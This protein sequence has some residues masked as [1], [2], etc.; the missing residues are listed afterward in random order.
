MNYE[1]IYFKCSC[2][3]TLTIGAEGIGMTFTCPECGQDLR[4]PEPA[5]K[6]QCECG[7][8]I[9]AHKSMIGETV[10]CL[11]CKTF[12]QVPGKQENVS[13][14]PELPEKKYAQIKS[15]LGT[16]IFSTILAGLVVIVVIS[17]IFSL[18][19]IE[20]PPL[21]ASLIGEGSEKAN[22][23][24]TTNQADE[25]Q[26]ASQTQAEAGVSVK[27]GSN[28]ANNQAAESQTVAAA[29]VPDKPIVS[30]TQTQAASPQIQSKE[31]PPDIKPVV[32]PE[33]LGR[34][35]KLRISSMGSTNGTQGEFKG[36]YAIT[37]DAINIALD[38][39][40][41]FSQ[42]GARL[43]SLQVYLAGAADDEKTWNIPG[44][45]ESV[46]CNLVIQPREKVHLK[47]LKFT[48][49]FTDQ[50]DLKRR[51]LSVK[52]W[53]INPNGD[54]EYNPAESRKDI[55]SRLSEPAKTSA[56]VV[57]AANETQM[58]AAAGSARVPPA[59]PP[60]MPVTNMSVAVMNMDNFIKVFEKTFPSNNNIALQGMAD[61]S[62]SEE[63]TDPNNVLRGKRQGLAWR[64]CDDVGREGGWF[65]AKWDNPVFGRFILFFK[66]PTVSYSPTGEIRYGGWR[67][68]AISVN[69]GEKF[70]I[71]NTIGQ[72][73]VMVD[74]QRQYDIQ[75]ISIELPEFSCDLPGLVGLEIHE[76][77]VVPKGE[78]T[79][80]NNLSLAQNW[81]DSPAA[82]RVQKDLSSIL[83]QFGEA[84]VDLNRNDGIIIFNNLTYLMDI[85]E[86]FSKLGER[87]PATT[88]LNT[89]YFA[90]RSFKCYTISKNFT[91]GQTTFDKIMFVADAKNQLIAVQ[92]VNENPKSRCLNSRGQNY[93]MYNI[94][95]NRQK[96]S[97]TARIDYNV[98]FVEGGSNTR[99]DK[100]N[101][102]CIESELTVRERYNYSAKEFVR[103][104][105]PVPIVNL[106]LYCLPSSK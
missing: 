44:E 32:P 58:T 64:L 85:K 27:L 71:K 51:W 82:S 50:I 93:S 75:S 102:L 101:V 87:V 100:S 13:R 16:N 73:V 15:W 5:C 4:V 84:N 88:P 78:T 17:V 59:G 81:K 10:Q 74:L 106:V 29:D 66:A 20:K 79:A 26:V 91:D 99:S 52:I 35:D 90:N 39:A 65:K 21:S 46:K 3:K 40:I 62:S 36:S 24:V 61:A 69:D 49:P 97:S 45:S 98:Y 103:L 60:V 42:R 28:A 55:F 86:V 34:S 47:D 19:R 38:D 25:S 96:A 11:S 30:A 76:A 105:L 80:I 41:V 83:G 94:I 8:I 53:W 9:F 72:Q 68:A 18:N 1:D 104:Y 37:A 31:S 92:L 89:P 7:A 23:V 67:D 43:D 57:A 6:L 14:D 22:S 48:I 12:W 56:P 63:N 54:T 33:L 95:Q 2:G 77:K 70:M